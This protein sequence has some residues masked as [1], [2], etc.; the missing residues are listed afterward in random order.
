MRTFIDRLRNAFKPCAG[1]V[2]APKIK[3]S[4]IKHEMCIRGRAQASGML[5]SQGSVALSRFPIVTENELEMRKERMLNY[6]FT[7]FK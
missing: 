3:P 1:V 6:D 2:H 5:V 7:S 4:L